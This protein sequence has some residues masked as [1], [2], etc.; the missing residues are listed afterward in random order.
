MSF[1]VCT[2]IVR[3]T[4]SLR[5]RRVRL[6]IDGKLHSERAVMCEVANSFRIAHAVPVTPGAKLTDGLLDTVV[7][8]DLRRSELVP[9]YKAFRAQLHQTLPKVTTIQARE[10]RIESRR[11][12]NVH[13]DDRAI[14]VTPATIMVAPRALK[15]LVD[16]L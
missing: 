8:G 9:Y 14:G 2:P 11:P 13:C 10:V 7:V 3:L 15:V 6:I 4:L 12:M 1:A 5:A 16:R